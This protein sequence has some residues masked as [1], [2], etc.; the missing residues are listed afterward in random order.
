MNSTS[1]RHRRKMTPIITTY[2]DRLFHLKFN[3]NGGYKQPDTHRYPHNYQPLIT[4]R[5]L[6]RPQ[7]YL[8]HLRAAARIKRKLLG[9]LVTVPSMETTD[10]RKPFHVI[11]HRYQV[12]H[13]DSASR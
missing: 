2:G 6:S 4:Q 1:R 8:S 9:Q 11:S 5:Y 12:K 13:R 7:V 3:S 10:P